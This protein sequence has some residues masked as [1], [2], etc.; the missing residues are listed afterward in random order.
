METASKV[1]A[2]VAL[3]LCLYLVPLRGAETVEHPYVGVTS[4][5]REETSPRP[6]RMHVI[7]IDLTTPGIRFELTPPGGSM[8]TVRRTTLEFLREKH[9]QIA[10]NSH[11]FLP[12]PSTNPD[13]MLIGLAA[14][15]GN[16]Y[17][18][19]ES[20]A[21]SYA[22]LADAPAINIDMSNHAGIVHRDPRF[23]DGKH[24]RENVMLW[25][26]LSGSAQIVT[27]GMKTI[28]VYKDAEHPDGLL[29]AGGPGAYSNGNS[30]YDALNARTAIGLTRD[31]RTLVLFTVDRGRV[32]EVADVLIRDYAV[33]NALNL[34][35]GGSTTLVMENPVTHAAALVND[36]SDNTA[37][38]SVGSNLAIFAAATGK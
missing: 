27:E 14:S 36:S 7:Q 29:T 21:Q 16:V 6:L 33:A 11:F 17:S 3:V 19:F 18:G 5:S 4:I 2:A 24:I 8:E 12:F 28:P 31:G 15:N 32:G 1:F 9:A 34:D 13:A 22:I 35:G 25:N 30:W 37:G 10:I 38:R 23:S 26:A 20:P